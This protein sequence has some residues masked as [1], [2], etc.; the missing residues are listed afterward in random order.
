M[1]DV[2]SKFYKAKKSYRQAAI[3]QAKMRQRLCELVLDNASSYERVFEFGAGQDELG[4]ILRPKIDFKKYIISDINE[5]ANSKDKVE[6]KRIDMSLPLPK[7]L[8]EFDLIVSNACMQWLDARS[9]LESLSHIL[10]PDAFLALSTFGKQ[11]LIQIKKLCGVGL[12]Y[13]DKDEL[14]SACKTRY[15]NI[16]ISSKTYNLHFNSAIDVFRHLKLS[17]VNSLGRVYISKEILN[18]CEKDFNNTLSYEAIFVTA[19]KK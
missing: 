14:L 7:D 15:K 10:K 13:L 3:A 2:A 12:E 1:Q 19:K 18:R 6:F 5:L 11:N 9:T 16:Q 4:Q 17:G 8:K